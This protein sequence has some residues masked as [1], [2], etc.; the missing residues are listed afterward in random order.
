EKI[1]EER[2]YVH[3]LEGGEKEKENVSAL[4]KSSEILRSRYGRLYVQFGQIL[5]FDEVYR[6]ELA[7]EDGTVPDPSNLTP[8]RRRL[9]VQRLAHRMVYEINRV[10]VVTPAALV[11]T[12]LLVHRR[13]GMTHEQLVRLSG[14]LLDSLDRL[15]AQVVPQ[16]RASDGG[17]REDTIQQALQLFLADRLVVQ[18]QA[19]DDPIY[20][21]PDERRINIEYYMNN[22]LH[23]FVPKALLSSALLA[24][25]GEPVTEQALRE[26]VREL[27]RLFKYEFMFR[28]DATFDAI[29][30]DA[31]G[32][33]LEANELERVGDHVRPSEGGSVII[34]MYAAMLRSYFESYMLALRGC[35]VLIEEKRLNRKEWLKRALVIGQRLYLAG[36]IELRESISKPRL[37]NAVKSMHDLGI[38]RL[39][40]DEKME[41]GKHMGDRDQLKTVERQLSPYLQ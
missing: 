9:L 5:S 16:L 38:V 11:A 19:D 40:P 29:F 22:I 3:E 35:T 12:A 7:A 36:G 34:R 37:E 13:R 6:E 33:M 10:T 30:D 39:I 32:D 17:V 41:A 23:F 25:A 24:G 8:P 4:I 2:S 27:S 1:V 18:H 15:G 31:L 26:R 28:A 20:A 14:Q 21:V